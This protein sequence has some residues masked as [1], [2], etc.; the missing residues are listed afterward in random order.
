MRSLLGTCDYCT[1]VSD[2]ASRRHLR[3]ASRRHL[4]VPQYLSSYGRR[5]FYVAGP[6]PGTLCE[7]SLAVDSFR[8]LLKARLFAEY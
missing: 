2:I 3:S 1:P 6:L 5:A 4:L 8:Q 7:P